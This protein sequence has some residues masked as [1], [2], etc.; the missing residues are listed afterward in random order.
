MVRDQCHLR[1]VVKTGV[2]AVCKRRQPQIQDKWQ[3]TFGTDKRTH[4]KNVCSC[5]WLHTDQRFR[6]ED[7][8]SDDVIMYKPDGQGLLE[9][10]SWRM[11]RL[12]RRGK[13]DDIIAEVRG[14]GGEGGRN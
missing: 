3:P 9:S 11:P 12:G 8:A 4:A 7:A 10:S 6:L 1:S 14:G 13:G 2:G 5:C